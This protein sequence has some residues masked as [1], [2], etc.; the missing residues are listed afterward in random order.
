MELVV[1]APVA[2]VGLPDVA[3][4]LLAADEA[5]AVVVVLPKRRRIQGITLRRN[6]EVIVRGTKGILVLAT[7]H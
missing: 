6:G 2:A 1:V 5:D 7:V 4:D 3:V